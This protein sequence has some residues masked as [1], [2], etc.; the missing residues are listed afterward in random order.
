MFPYFKVDDEYYFSKTQL[1][2]WIKEA[3]IEQVEY[4]T[5]EVW[6]R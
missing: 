3:T 2:E 4:N 1:D 6:M 5:A